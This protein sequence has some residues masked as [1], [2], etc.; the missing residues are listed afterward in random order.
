CPPG[1]PGDLLPCPAPGRRGN[2]SPAEVVG[3]FQLF[4][5]PGSPRLW[6]FP[7]NGSVDSGDLGAPCVDPDPGSSHFGSIGFVDWDSGA[8][9][10]F[11]TPY[12]NFGELIDQMRFLAKV[13]DSSAQEVYIRTYP[14][15]GLCFMGSCWP[16][17][18]SCLDVPGG[19]LYSNAPINYFPCHGGQNQRW[20]I[21]T[22]PSLDAQNP[23]IVSDVNGLC[24]DVPWASV[25][26]G[27][28]LQTYPCHG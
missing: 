9:A 3:T 23:R 11:L 21:Y 27:Q 2:G 16:S 7:M 20:W 28:N 10:G 5:V 24:I 13:R 14:L 12:A 17:V 26:S 8:G 18:N 15:W 4:I 22:D 1:Y 19:A 25:T 6:L